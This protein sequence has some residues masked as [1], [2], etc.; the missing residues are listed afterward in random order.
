MNVLSSPAVKRIV[1]ELTQHLCRYFPELMQICPPAERE[2]RIREGLARAGELGLRSRQDLY[3]FMNLSA[4]IGWDFLERADSQ[5]MRDWLADPAR[6]DP[7][8]RLRSLQQQILF[9]IEMQQRV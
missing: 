5:W 4:F 3:R 8:A 9:N 1:A 6:G 7:G 2:Q